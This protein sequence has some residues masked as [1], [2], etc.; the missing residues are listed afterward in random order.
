MA[1]EKDQID[2]ITND[3]EET[4]TKEDIQDEIKDDDADTEDII[5]N[6]RNYDSEIIER[7]NGIEDKL[8]SIMQK[9]SAFATDA[10]LIDSSPVENNND[11]VVDSPPDYRDFDLDI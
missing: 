5:E 3:E 9:F 11:M 2:G 6:D 4:D 8:N 7:I 1:D 10:R